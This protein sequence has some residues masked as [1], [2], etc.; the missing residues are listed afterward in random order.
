MP[1]EVP[2]LDEWEMGRVQGH[3][4]RGALSTEPSHSSED[5]EQRK[6][7]TAVSCVEYWRRKSAG[8]VETGGCVED[9]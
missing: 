5:T 8:S 6:V 7:N 4:Q 3:H 2:M 1:V 9:C